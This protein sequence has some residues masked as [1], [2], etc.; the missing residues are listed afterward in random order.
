MWV[1]STWPHLILI[2]S[3]KPPFQTPSLGGLG[4]NIWIYGGHNIQSL[5][6]SYPNGSDTVHDIFLFIPS[7]I[8]LF[9][10]TF[11][12]APASPRTTTY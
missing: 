10:N 8:D 5:A 6:A 1:I 7:F 11:S 2:I 9:M 12:W 4:F 3:W